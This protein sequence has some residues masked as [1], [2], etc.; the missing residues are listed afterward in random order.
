MRGTDGLFAGSLMTLLACSSTTDEP[1]SPPC[2]VKAVL[3]E[4]CDTCH[5][6][7]PKNGAPFSLVT[8]ADTQ[9]PLTELPTYDHTPTWKVMGDAVS[10][11]LMPQPW[12]GVTFTTNQRQ[13]LLAWVAAG[14]P[15]M[16]P[17]TQ[18]P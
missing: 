15:A 13:T 6:S 16:A 5:S 14:A 18:C 9:A 7:P 10:S 4:V 17:G 1:P 2:D 8:Y 11:G 3:S 12:P